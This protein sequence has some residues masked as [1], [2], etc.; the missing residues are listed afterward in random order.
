M[1]QAG[2]RTNLH[3]FERLATVVERRRMIQSDSPP[4]VRIELA[5]FE[6]QLRTMHDSYAS[7]LDDRRLLLDRCQLTDFAFTVVGGDDMGTRCYIVLPEGADPDDALVLQF[8][9][10]GPSALEPFD[11]PR[12]YPTGG[13]RVV[14]EQPLT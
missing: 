12:T 13:A 7:P 3:A 5:G 4:L 11:A 2:R 14:A 10:A 6:D 9:Q 1:E 8:T